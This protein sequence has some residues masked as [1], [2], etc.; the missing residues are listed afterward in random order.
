MD[1]PVGVLAAGL[2]DRYAALIKGRQPGQHRR[3]QPWI[4]AEW[5]NALGRYQ[6]FKDKSLTSDPLH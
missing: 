1:P 3:P 4:I 5:R 2:A 6:G